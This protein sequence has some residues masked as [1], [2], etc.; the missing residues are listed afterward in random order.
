MI[1]LAK[2]D[3]FITGVCHP[4]DNVDLI[5]KANIGWVRNDV[6][7][8]FKPG[9]FGELTPEY[10]AYRNRV[11]RYADAGLKTMCVTPYPRA[12]VEF[13][14]DPATPEGLEVVERTLEWLARDL[15]A[16][17][18]GGYQITNE[19]N[20]FHFRIP[21]TLEQAPAYIIAGIKGVHKGDPDAVLGYNSAGVG[22][23]VQKMI[24][25]I[26]PYHHML[27]YM[28]VD[29]YRGTWSDGE[30]DDI[31]SEIDAAYNAVGLPVL[32]Q[33]FGFS[34]KGEIYTEEE[35]LAYVRSAGF[36]SFEEVYEDPE[37]FVERLPYHLAKRVMESPRE[38]WAENALGFIP[39]LLRKWPGGS[40]K[41]R[42][43][44]EGQ[45]AFYDEV[46]TKMLAHPHVCGAFVYSWSDPDVCFNCRYPNCPCETAWGITT[47]DEEPKPAYYVVQKHFARV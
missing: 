34:S 12:F 41:Y 13:G 29:S 11:N 7:F 44:N 46:L 3:R 26:K 20:V 4:R 38:D 23:D 40:K 6:P 1:I 9:K 28:G 22:P 31:I 21:L 43:T 17:G 32:V 35:A 37:G 42:H 14:I 19:L 24:E 30:P 47:P 5:K 33:E 39:H 27:D 36:E 10:I 16:A 45:A 8:P 18:V 25:E 15:K 2:T